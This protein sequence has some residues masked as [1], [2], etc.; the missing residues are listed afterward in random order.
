M[1]VAETINGRTALVHDHPM[2]VGPVGINGSA[3][4][5]MLAREADVILAVGTRLQ[6]LVT[7]SWT[8]FSENAR[9]IGLNA[10]RYHPFISD[11]A[12]ISLRGLFGIL[13]TLLLL[14]FLLALGGI[15]FKLWTQLG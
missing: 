7:G 15:G 8:V 6:D 1:P 13:Y 10:A 5:N 14:G 11:D 4:A 9:F 3:S 12:L 2:N